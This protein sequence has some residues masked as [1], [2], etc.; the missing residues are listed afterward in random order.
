MLEKIISSLTDL[1]LSLLS[2]GM[3][4]YAGTV[5]M[6]ITHL[7]GGANRLESQ[8]MPSTPNPK[9]D[10]ALGGGHCE[11]VWD[12]NYTHRYLTD[13]EAET[14]SFYVDHDFIYCPKC[15]RKIK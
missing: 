15:G 2:D 4:T 8:V 9:N 14:G 11:W 13:C 7:R 12:D 6:I 3:H 5:N 1:K 10:G